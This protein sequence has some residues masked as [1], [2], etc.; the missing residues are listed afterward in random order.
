MKTLLVAV[1]L[2]LVAAYVFVLDFTVV[3]DRYRFAVG[4]SNLDETI[5]TVPDIGQNLSKR[6]YRVDFTSSSAAEAENDTAPRLGLRYPV[7]I[8]KRI[9]VT[10]TFGGSDLVGSFTGWSGTMML[11]DSGFG[12]PAEVNLRQIVAIEKSLG[13]RRGTGKGAIIG[14]VLGGIWGG[15]I[16]AAA[17]LMAQGN[18]QPGGIVVVG[19][20]SVGLCAGIGA[21][22]G[23]LIGSAFQE[24]ERWETVDFPSVAMEY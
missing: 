23:A 16:T 3:P 12:V 5:F 24:P 2:L 22:L 7:A 18:A 6:G 1:V 21:G 13:R 11:V 20:L 8:G 19:I 9:R 14:G 15:L 10:T 17:A 4:N